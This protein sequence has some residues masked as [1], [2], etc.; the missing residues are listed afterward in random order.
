MGKLP[1]F[2]DLRAV[3]IGRDSAIIIIEHK[4]YDTPHRS[5]PKKGKQDSKHAH[6]R[7]PFSP[8]RPHTRSNHLQVT[9][10]DGPP[11]AQ[12][13]PYILPFVKALEKSGH[14]VS[15]IIP[16]TQRSWIGK[17][18]IVGQDV[19]ATPYH[20]PASNPESHIDGFSAPD[21]GRAPWILVNSTPA[22]CSQIGLGH[23][24]KDRGEVDLVVSGPNYGRN[25]GALFALS[26]GTLG[27]ALEAAQLGRRA[28]ALSFAFFDRSNVPEVVAEA[29]AQSV[30]VV[31]WLA[32]KAAW[33][34]SRLY[35]VNVPVKKG[36]LQ[37][38]VRWTKMLQNTWGEG[39]CFQE[40]PKGA[41]D[42]AA[43]EEARLRRQESGG[44]EEEG[45]VVGGKDGQRHFKWAPQFADVMNNARR[46][47]P[48]WDGWTVM[49]GETSVTALVANYVHA[50]VPEGELKL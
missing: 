43:T 13:S 7:E 23:F 28:V 41:V 31:E 6:P 39:C 3:H 1:L 27:A 4:T 10:D 37:N 35:S 22:S 9:N 32:A 30:R 50:D 21:E 24:F 40:L 29:C 42:D 49:E 16:N 44:G 5:R 26:S 15:V 18:H 11:S 19:Q 8:P 12:A 47:G 45:G 46:A 33:G 20:P 17:A 34:H 2:P 25:T 36:V 48:G 38:K 14:T